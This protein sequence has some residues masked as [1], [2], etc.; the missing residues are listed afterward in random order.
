[1]RRAEK[2]GQG[3]EVRPPCLCQSNLVGPCATISGGAYRQVPLSLAA[4]ENAG[5]GG[6]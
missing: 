2:V 1:M 6:P 4:A 3:R 5:Q